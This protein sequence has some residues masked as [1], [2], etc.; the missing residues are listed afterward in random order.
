M[1]KQ[2]DINE[3]PFLFPIFNAFRRVLKPIRFH[4]V[5]KQNL[6]LS[7]RCLVQLADGARPATR[8]FL[9]RS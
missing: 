7:T 6:S 8:H 2:H 4:Q 3:F 9:L 1:P 5:I